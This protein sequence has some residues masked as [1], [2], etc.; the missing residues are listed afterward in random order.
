MWPASIRI[1]MR[2]LLMLLALCSGLRLAAAADPVDAYL[3]GMKASL[4]QLKTLQA[5]F[6]QERHLAVFEDT[7][8]SQG[9]LAFSTPDKLRW[10]LQQPYHS[11][12]LLN[13]SGVAKW[14]V[15]AGQARRAKLGGKE[16]LQAALGQILAMLR[17]DFNSLKTGFDIKLSLG[18]AGGLDK[19]ALKP[20]G[21]A[22]AKYLS[23][24]EFSIDPKRKRVVRLKL[25]EPGGDD[26]DVRFSHEK[27]DAALDAKLFDLDHPLLE[28]VKP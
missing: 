25:L 1:E 12:L 4:G 7:L 11:V 2:T 24:L 16:A 15:E 5:G 13:G 21:Q 28:G 8:K 22:L 18:K 20:K 6:S 3:A 17:G 19:L 27:E 10:E 23:G 14:D 9:Q 26:T